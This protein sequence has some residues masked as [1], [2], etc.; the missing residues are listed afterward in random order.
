MKKLAKIIGL[1]VL[2]LVVLGIAVLFFL[3]RM[4]DPNDYKD[5]IRELLMHSIIYCGIPMAVDGFRSAT[6]VLKDLGLE[7]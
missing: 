6:E 4:F 3:T 7:P 2:A 5:E 1:V